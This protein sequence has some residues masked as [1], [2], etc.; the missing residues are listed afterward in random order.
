MF[1]P[2]AR[3]ETRLGR[4][5]RG[6]ATRREAAS[7]GARARH[8]TVAPA[9]RT[10]DIATVDMFSRARG[11]VAFTSILAARSLGIAE[12]TRDFGERVP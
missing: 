9:A 6:A 1:S 7:R 2:E 8:A 4:G 11:E 12:T 10:D 5:A 3:T